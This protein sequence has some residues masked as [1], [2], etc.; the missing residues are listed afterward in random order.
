MKAQ[1]F[2][3]FYTVVNHYPVTLSFK[4]HEDPCTN[5]RARVVNMHA[6]VLS[7]VRAFTVCLIHNFQCILHI[8]TNMNL[9]NLQRWIITEGLW[10]FFKTKSQNGW[11]S[12]KKMRPCFNILGNESPFMNEIIFGILKKPPV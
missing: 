10:N 2:M 1:I 6:H 12:V 9:Q 11:S 3:K 4:F 7:R 5:E 8:F